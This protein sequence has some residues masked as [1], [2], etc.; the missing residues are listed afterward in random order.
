MD[1][2]SVWFF[3]LISFMLYGGAIYIFWI[4]LT[5]IQTTYL[6]MLTNGKLGLGSI[7]SLAA[8]FV[9]L[10]GMV[11]VLPYMTAKVIQKS[12]N[13]YM[14]IMLDITN[15]V[16]VD[17]ENMTKG[18]P[19]V[20]T[21]TNG[22]TPA[23]SNG[24]VPSQNNVLIVPQNNN[25]LVNPATGQSFNDTQS[26]GGVPSEMLSPPISAPT[27]YVVPTPIIYPTIDPA[28]WK[29][30]DPAPTPSP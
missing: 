7:V 23:G 24:F 2:M 10:F 30:G 5:M 18:T 21:S 12:F 9:I 29:Y 6:P 22:Q 3:R 13:M 1:E 26:G 28:T 14:P 27:P 8:G 15:Q 17:V 20:Y 11:L 16:V 19:P 4:I 25:V